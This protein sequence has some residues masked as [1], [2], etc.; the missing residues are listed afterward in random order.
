MRLPNRATKG[1][2]WVR[3]AADGKGKLLSQVGD[4]KI[5]EAQKLA[6]E[7]KPNMQ[8]PSR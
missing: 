8:S 5:A 1:R 3:G 7:W 6:R 4:K 2:Q